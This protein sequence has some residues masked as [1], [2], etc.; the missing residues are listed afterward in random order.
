MK[1]TKYNMAHVLF[2][3]WPTFSLPEK[4]KKENP[5][6]KIIEW[7]VELTCFTIHNSALGRVAPPK[8]RNFRTI[9]M[10]FFLNFHA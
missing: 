5:D 3:H 9:I 2:F 10:Q 8:R 1:H 4:L 6:D 7:G